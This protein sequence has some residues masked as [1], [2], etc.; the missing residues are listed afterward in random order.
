MDA[1]H[2]GARSEIAEK[3]KN[4]AYEIIQRKGATYY[5]IAMSVKRICEA[6]IRDE[7]SILPISTMMDG[8]YGIKDVVLSMPSIVGAEGF[9]SK[10]PISLSEDEIKAL[11]KSAETLKSVL[12]EA[13]E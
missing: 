7:R 5:G 3:V 13:L 6:I 10:V 1:Y 8:E 9:I 4:S 2:E 11:H 12:E